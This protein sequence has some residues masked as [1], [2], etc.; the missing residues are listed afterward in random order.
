MGPIIGFDYNLSSYQVM[1]IA[2]GL[3]D[4]DTLLINVNNP[5]AG[6]TS[7]TTVR[8]KMTGPNSI[9]I[10]GDKILAAEAFDLLGRN[11]PTETEKNGGNNLLY[12][13]KNAAF[14][15]LKTSQGSTIIRVPFYLN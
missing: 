2:A 14:I 3:C 7:T 12:F 4:S 1:L 11:C 9:Q 8:W 5:N 13:A 10:E 15:K 6:L